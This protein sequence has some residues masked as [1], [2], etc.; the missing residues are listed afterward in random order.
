MMKAILKMVLGC[1]LLLLLSLAGPAPEPSAARGHLQGPTPGDYGDAPDSSNNPGVNP[2]SA[3]PGIPGNFPTAWQNTPAGQGA[4]PVHFNPQ[5]FLGT[6]VS[7]EAAADGG[8][9]PD[10]ANNIVDGGLD[11]A[12]K[13]AFDDGWLN[14]GTLFSHCQQ[15]TLEVRVRRAAAAAG[16]GPMFLNVWFD[17]NRDGDWADQ[18]T[19]PGVPNFPVAR[20]WI[21][22]NYPINA[23]AIA[24]GGFQDLVINTFRVP[25]G[26]ENDSHW[27]RFTLSEQAIP[28]GGGAI[29]DGRGPFPPNGYQH[30]ET[31]DYLYTPPP[32]GP[33]GVVVF[34][35]SVD[36]AGPLD[37]GDIVT[38]TITLDIQGAAITPVRI[39]DP[40]PQGVTFVGPITLQSQGPGQVTPLVAKY[41]EHG[42][43]AI[44]DQDH[45][46]IWQ[47]AFLPPKKLRLKFPV[48]LDYCFNGGTRTISN[49]AKATELATGQSREAQASLTVNCLPIG[50]ADLAVS[51][52]VLAQDG[53][54]V[55]ATA[56]PADLVPGETTLV[57]TSLTNN[58]P[59]PLILG[60][61]ELL[62][63]EDP[64]QS[65]DP[66][67]SRRRSERLI[68][69]PGQSKSWSSRLNLARFFEGSLPPGGLGLEAQLVSTLQMCLLDQDD[70]DCPDPGTDP[71][72]V[73]TLDPLVVKIRQRDLGDA[74][75][76]TNHFGLAMTAYPAVQADFPTVYDPASGSPPG[77]VH[78]RPR[79]FHL[80][81][82]VSLEV[83]ADVGP[84][85][86]PVNNL[87][88]AVN[89]ANRDRADDGIRPQLLTFNHCQPAIFPAKIFIS[90]AAVAYFT[91]QDDDGLAY[92]NVWLDA[93]RDGDWADSL[94]C[95]PLAPEHIVVDQSI[96][97]GA[98]GPGLHTVPVATTGPV[99]WPNEPAGQPA[100]LRL[101]L[102]D[103]P[104]EKLPGLPYGDGRGAVTPYRMG[105]T[106]DYL[107]NSPAGEPELH[108]SGQAVADLTPSRNGLHAQAGA[109]RWLVEWSWGIANPESLGP[110][111]TPFALEIDGLNVGLLVESTA[112]PGIKVAQNGNTITFTIDPAT[113]DWAD[114]E[115]VS[116]VTEFYPASPTDLEVLDQPVQA[117]LIIDNQ[118][119]ATVGA[120]IEAGPA[121]PILAFAGP[122]GAIRTAGATCADTIQLAGR[123]AA[124]ATVKVWEGTD[125]RHTSTAG[126]N[127]HWSGHL[128][129]PPGAHRLHATQE[130][131][132]RTSPGSNIIAILIG[133]LTGRPDLS[134]LSLTD[135]A[136]QILW[137]EIDD[138]VRFYLQPGQSYT[139]SVAGCGSNPALQLIL[140]GDGLDPVSLTDPDGD[141]LYQ[142]SFVYDGTS[143]TI[144][145]ALSAITGSSEVV[146]PGEFRN[147]E[148]YQAIVQD[149]TTGQSLAASAVSI[150]SPRA[151][152]SGLPGGKS[153]LK[154]WPGDLFGQ[155][156][157]QT[158]GPAG[159]FSPWLVPDDTYQFLVTQPGYQPF[160]TF[161]VPV[162]G[163]LLSSPLGL[164]QVVANPAQ[165]TV[166]ID[167]TG[168]WPAVATVAPGTVVAWVNTRL[169]EHGAAGSGWSSGALGPGD[170]FKKQ[171]DSPG[172][173]SYSDP[174]NPAHTA[175]IIVTSSDTLYLPLI[176]K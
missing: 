55:D 159:G 72:R 155:P 163:G 95:P 166:T 69:A 133:L 144:M 116:F 40:L 107:L 129:L 17:G 176:V 136:G 154:L 158:T 125:L 138:G 30:G 39:V 152:T 5:L 130:I 36:A 51:R 134:T 25:N 46:V 96:D 73:K 21:V 145:F 74:P 34:S 1:G 57:E 48:R 87:R 100:W 83:E 103:I 14:P 91:N 77:P 101:S 160:R 9:D 140:D 115:A 59:I 102:S 13:E 153:F 19:C 165:V 65:P 149:A 119:K 164:S 53:D 32:G 113:V 173:F 4:G 143:N 29:P 62:D 157:P 27:L 110:S 112:G 38:Y 68:L 124:G 90:P 146:V 54:V 66:L 109:G 156:N 31:E 175:T 150:I 12:D 42:P 168:F 28:A 33:P 123:A 64:A 171:F 7:V 118:V 41:F 132:G 122:N 79:Y 131:G 139:L 75:D 22:R 172:A 11:E 18:V 81:Q 26:A 120:T 15:T 63:Y 147:R 70:W 24:A 45:L 167:E 10:G 99:P 170:S 3:Y 84:D 2:N 114:L 111:T 85:Q 23:G 35:K 94:D 148:A 37:P 8:A 97:V 88:P 117:N 43:P 67:L 71:E 86:E 80:G 92:L 98:L 76:S 141:G 142:G 93:N 78:L 161:E 151:A 56:N 169:A 162:L 16:A 174:A 106:E 105:E 89:L 128:T 6:D 49:V 137:P 60:V 58:G 61:R 108:L 126:S 20:E 50:F 121:A 135:G 52:R 104:S 82:R 127:G 44:S 47:G